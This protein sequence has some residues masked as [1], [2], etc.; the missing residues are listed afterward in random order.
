MMI[1]RVL[2]TIAKVM[3]ERVLENSVGR[4]RTQHQYIL[5]LSS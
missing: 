5:Q 1:V 2:I 4:T 3:E